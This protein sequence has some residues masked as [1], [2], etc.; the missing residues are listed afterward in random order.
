[1]DETQEAI[2]RDA[3][4]SHFDSQLGSLDEVA[5]RPARSLLWLQVLIAM[6]LGTG[7]GLWLSPTGGGVLTADVADQVASWCVLPGDLFL[8]MIQMVVLPLIFSSIVLGIAGGER[9]DTLARVGKRLGPYFVLTTCVS[10]CI[11]AAVALLIQPG[12]YVDA[13][14]LSSATSAAEDPL[15]PEA[16]AALAESTLP[17]ELGALIPNNLISAAAESAMLQ[18]VV[19]AMFA[20]V[21]IRSIDADRAAPLL[22]LC[23]SLLEVAMKVVSWAMLLA[24]IAVFGLL[25]DVMLRVGLTAILGVAAYVGAVLLGLFLL[26][27]FYTLV[28]M[29]LGGRAPWKFAAALRDLQLLAFSTSSSAAVMPVSLTT[30]TEKLGVRDSIAS[31]VV[32]LGATVNMDGTALYQ[33]CAAVFLTQVYG[34]DLSTGELI[35]LAATTVGASIGTPSTPGVGIAILATI[36]AGLGVPAGGIALIL[37]V[38][39]ILDM[40]RTAVNVSGDVTACVVMDRMIGGDV[41]PGATPAT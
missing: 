16:A 3:Y 22:R 7:I 29:F 31:V 23:E 12:A 37:G 25:C 11:G 20:G 19:A 4:E 34:I 8:N 41:A 15:V 24:P 38:D 5:K 33:V 6:V 1:M 36:L 26:L 2:T 30:A 40:C 35:V 21:A 10:V 17:K 39:R 27:V 13:E 9:N 14:L 18:L 32:P 28:A